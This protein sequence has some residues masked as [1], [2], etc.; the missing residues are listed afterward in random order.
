MRADGQPGGVL[1]IA[2]KPGNAEDKIGRPQV[3]ESGTYLR[4]AVKKHWTGPVAFDNA[5]RCAPGAKE[6]TPGQVDACRPYLAQ[7]IREVKPTRIVALGAQAYAAILGRKPQPFSVRRGFGWLNLDD[8]WIPVFLTLNPA[9]TL[10]NRFVRNWFDEDLKWALTAEIPFERPDATTYNVI[11]SAADAVRAV[12]DL[13]NSRWFAYDCEWTGRI[14]GPDFNLTNVAC[15]AADSDHAWVWDLDALANPAI[16]EPLSRLMADPRALKVG[17]SMSGDLHAIERGLATRVNGVFSDAKV[18]RKLLDV[19]I[20]GDLEIQAELVGMGGHKQE[21]ETQRQQ[22]VSNLQKQLS[23]RATG[24]RDLFH[25][26]RFPWLSQELEDLCVKQMEAY[27]KAKG[28]EKEKLKSFTF[29]MVHTEV[30]CRYNGRDAVATARLQSLLE[31]QLVGSPV[32]RIWH[33]VVRDS[34]VAFQRMEAWGMAI[35]RGAVNAF[36]GYLQ[37]KVAVVDQKLQPYLPASGINWDSPPQIADLLFKQLQLPIQGTTDGGAPSTD[38]EALKKL[39]DL[40]PVPEL[41]LERRGLIKM[42]GTYAMGLLRHQGVDGRIHP[43]VHPDGARSGRTSSSDPNLQNIPRAE[44]TPEGRMIKD[45]FVAPRGKLLLQLDYSQL[46]FRVWAMLSGDPELLS[47]FLSGID[48]HMRTAQ[49]IA[50]TMWNED[51]NDYLQG[52]GK[53]T[54]KG[55]W[56]RYLAKMINFGTLYGLGVGTLARRM[57]CTKDEA[58]RVQQMILGKF[59]IGARWINDQLAYCRKHGVSRTWWDGEVARVRN[60][61]RIADQDDEVRVQAEHG[62]WNSPIQGTAADFCTK[63]MTQVVNAIL[64]DGL[65][66]KLI[67]S[68]HDALLL[69]VDEGDAAEVAQVVHGIMHGQPSNGFP[70]E[71]D[72]D[73]GR[74]WGT[75][76]GVQTKGEDGVVIPLHQAVEKTVEKMRAAA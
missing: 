24:Q 1:L 44:D 74:S 47:A 15:S 20:S 72:V 41:I 6:V 17:W 21:F 65:P 58:E 71:V 34:I 16:T 69:E 67:M 14:Y 31:V 4:H 46:E 40:H 8:T 5:V 22:A 64:M 33:N 7:T 19:E 3:G 2:E 63:S 51:P 10:R 60:M 23:R 57:G 42:D 52:D 49:S 18:L 43:S 53:P 13:R 54:P 39:K 28:N 45:C 25:H 35:D 37:A 68:I 36:H 70:L 11:A 76:Y 38:E 48:F 30:M 50:K 32:E 75:M 59:R 73:V 55:K 66:A 26:R 29:P 12:E 56:R 27:A 9:A 61:Y 62:S